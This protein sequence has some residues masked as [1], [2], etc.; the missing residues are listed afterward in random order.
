MRSRLYGRLPPVFPERPARHRPNRHRP[1]RP[2]HDNPSLPRQI[3]EICNRRRACKRR[4]IR[5]PSTSSKDCAHCGYRFL[6]NHGPISIHYRHGGAPRPQRIRNHVPRHR[7][8][9]QQ[10][11]FPPHLVPQRPHQRLRHI[12]R[13]RHRHRQPQT[14]KRPSRR[15]SH[16]SNFQVPKILNSCPQQLQPPSQRPRP[17]RARHN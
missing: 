9:R 13:R 12:F 6:R 16:R 4:S 15:R 14:L 3:Q 8:P 17:I 2:R 10:H 5:N 11:P 1:H 7:R